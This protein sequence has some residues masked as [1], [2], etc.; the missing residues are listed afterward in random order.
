LRDTA[1]KIDMYLAVVIVGKETNF[2]S[3]YAV[4]C[5]ADDY[6]DGTLQPPK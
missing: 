1:D 5:Y 3:D 2:S 4:E 6:Y